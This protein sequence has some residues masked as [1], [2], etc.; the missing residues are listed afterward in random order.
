MSKPLIALLLLATALPLGCSGTDVPPDPLASRTGFCKAWGESACNEDVIADCNANSKD[1]CVAKQSDFCLTLI[2]TA[3][4]SK[5]AKECLSAVTDAYKDTELT[6][7]EIQIVTQFAAPCDQLSRGSVPGG[8]TCK[9][10]DDCNT[11]DGY[12]CLIKP[13]ETRG[14]CLKPEEV[15]PGEACDGPAQVCETGYFCDG[16]N[17]L[18]FRKT[19]KPCTADYECL[20]SD[21]CAV[22]EADPETSLC[23]TRAP[24]N[25]D[26]TSDAECASNYCA[27]DPDQTVGAC[28]LKVVLGRREPL[29]ANLRLP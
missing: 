21:Q 12:G 29:C 18:A 24:L 9:N 27:I 28:V 13:G 8:G 14:A 7:E 1:D 11:A 4:D 23:T 15:K 6:A 19:N 3:Y 26:C 10:H 20:P 16:E 2:P 25:A 22:S 17:C 5:Y